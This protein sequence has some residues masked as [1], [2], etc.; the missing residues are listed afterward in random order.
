MTEERKHEIESIINNTLT[1]KDCREWAAGNMTD[2]VAELLKQYNIKVLNI[3]DDCSEIVEFNKPEIKRKS[4]WDYNNPDHTTDTVETTETWEWSDE[5][6]RYE[7][8]YLEEKATGE[9]IPYNETEYIRDGAI[10]FD[11]EGKPVD[12]HNATTI[13]TV[14]ATRGSGIDHGLRG[15]RTGA[16][17]IIQLTN[18]KGIEVDPA[19]FFHPEFSQ[20]IQTGKRIGFLFPH[21]QGY[22][23][24]LE[25]YPDLAE[26]YE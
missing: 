22:R 8:V 24:C 15:N 20:K 6:E 9:Y 18:G 10:S 3:W 14:K 26:C 16:C 25:K 21:D 23:E 4:T 1:E 2:H 12:D 19:L 17:I 13:K 11:S 5:L 7:L